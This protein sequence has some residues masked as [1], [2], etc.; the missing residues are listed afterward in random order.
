MMLCIGMV[1]ICEYTAEENRLK[2]FG[3]DVFKIGEKH[4]GVERVFGIY[5][6]GYPRRN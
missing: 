4:K 2:W 1:S 5:M 6:K 3:M